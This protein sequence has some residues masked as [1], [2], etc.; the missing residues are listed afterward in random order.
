[1]GAIRQCGQGDNL[2]GVANGR[3]SAHRKVRMHG[4]KSIPHETVEKSVSHTF[5]WRFVLRKVAF[6]CA[7]RRGPRTLKGY[8]EKRSGRE[9]E[10]ET[11]IANPAFTGRFHRSSVGR[12]AR[13]WP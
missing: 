10:I 7:A 5:P 4:V 6:W 1:M 9:F 12:R 8:S 3:S 2:C 11:A 13:N